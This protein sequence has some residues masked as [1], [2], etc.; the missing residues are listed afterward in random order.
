MELFDRTV[1]CV[2]KLKEF[3]N[4]WSS[5]E[6]IKVSTKLTDC[7]IASNFVGF[8]DVIDKQLI[9]PSFMKDPNFLEVIS[10]DLSFDFNKPVNVCRDLVLLWLC[11]IILI[12]RASTIEESFHKFSCIS[13]CVFLWQMVLQEPALYLMELGNEQ[14][15]KIQN[16]TIEKSRLAEYF[17]ERA[18]AHTLYYEYEKVEEC[19]NL[20][21]QNASIN[22][23]LT[24]ALG[25]RTRFQVKDVAQ[26]IAKITT[27]NDEIS[28]ATS[29]H[30]HSL[31]TN[32]ALNHE[33]LLESVALSS[34]TTEGIERVELTPI[35]LAAVLSFSIC[36]RAI[37]AKDELLIEKCLA[38]ITEVLSRPISWAVHAS[39]LLQRCELEM[40]QSKTV[41][42]A[43]CQ[44]EV[45]SKLMNGVDEDI[46]PSEKME[47]TNL[48]LASGLKPFW[49]VERLLANI[50]RSLG[51]TE[52]ALR[53]YEKLD[54]WDDIVACYRSL[55]Q[56]G[57]AESLVRDL[58][59]KDSSNAM[60]YCLLGDISNEPKHYKKALELSDRCPR[61]Y[62]SLGNLMLNRHAYEEAFDNLKRSVELQP[63]QLGVWFN[64]GHCAW[65][66]NRYHEASAAYH[67][68]VCLEPEYFEAWNNLSA[69]YI[70]LGQKLRAR[71]ILQEALRFN[72]DHANIWENYLLICVDTGELGQAILA[73]NR[74]LDLKNKFE[75]D[76]IIDILTKQVR[77]YDDGTDDAKNPFLPELITLLARITAK[78]TNSAKVWRCYASLKK[79]K[80]SEANADSYN[81]YVHLLE[82]ALHVGRLKEDW[83]KDE[84]T[85]G[86]LL[87]DALNLVDGKWKLHEMTKSDENL[88]KG[89]IRLE[90]R[91]I[92]KAVEQ[93]YGE[94]ACELPNQGVKEALKNIKAEL[95]RVS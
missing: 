73:Y 4:G 77:E 62:R 38:Y 12:D 88:L 39:A 16:F 19:I 37:E 30:C 7:F 59:N 43:C 50:L 15:K 82:R 57:K 74:L 6:T 95:L 47:R 1:D 21:L 49:C 80:P 35:Q 17:L 66:L 11:K 53:I 34:S 3:V 94:D 72:Y 20:A 45:L 36:G 25:R 90:L 32:V 68:C 70:R 23:E 83:F 46:N 71:T 67:R 24:G 2:E 61:A 13:R 44:A 55:Q 60:F 84:M 75:D 56:L 40:H 10:K 81:S 85:C 58:I 27:S 41:E 29:S 91:P 5:D 93:Q 92:V 31:P 48:V 51:C 52:E 63:I 89:E 54:A 79:P 22:I 14:E 26:L 78:Q 86:R 64:I 69:T 9:L 65:K 18:H 42:R 28:I 33:T 87:L 76:N 8:I